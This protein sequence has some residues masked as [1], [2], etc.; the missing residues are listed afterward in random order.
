M[1]RSPDGGGGPAHGPPGRPRGASPA[2]PAPPARPPPRPLGR[3]PPPRKPRPRPPPPPPPKEDKPRRA[4]QLRTA[5]TVPMTSPSP[6]LEPGGDLR[7]VEAL[8]RARTAIVEQ[9]EKRIVGQREVVEHLLI[10]LFSR[11]HCL[12]VGVPGLA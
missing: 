3:A 4:H 7:A 11:G 1:E 10:A 2:A 9:I 8:A 5:M 6:S 12:F